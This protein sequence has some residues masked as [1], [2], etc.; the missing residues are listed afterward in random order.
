MLQDFGKLKKKPTT[1]EWISLARDYHP[2]TEVD[3]LIKIKDPGSLNI[4][5][6]INGVFLGDAL[7]DLEANINLM[8]LE[9]LKKIKGLRMIPAEKLVGVVD[10]TLHEPE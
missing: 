8:S 6:S 2:N 4:P 5:I 7:C 9:T 1:L 3:D 10:G